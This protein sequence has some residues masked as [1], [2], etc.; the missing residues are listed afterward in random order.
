MVAKRDL[1][2]GE[3]VTYE[4]VESPSRARLLT[5]YGFEG[6]AP[7]A[8]IAADGV[9]YGDGSGDA[10]GCPS[11]AAPRIELRLDG[12][13]K[14]SDKRNAVRIAGPQRSTT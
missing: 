1:Q 9:H 14:L 8:S 2:P 3:E 6:D 5:A 4:Y 11:G 12:S 10:I 13:G 7:D